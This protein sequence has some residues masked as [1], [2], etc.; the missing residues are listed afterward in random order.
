MGSSKNKLFGV[1]RRGHIHIYI[2]TGIIL[3]IYIERERDTISNHSQLI[4]MLA[5]IQHAG[6]WEALVACKILP[7][8]VGTILASG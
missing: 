1:L 8:G 6:S 4:C 7:L 2:Y 3:Y 5:T